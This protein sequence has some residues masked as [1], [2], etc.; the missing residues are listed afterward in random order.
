MRMHM[1]CE[2]NVNP[3]AYKPIRATHPTRDHKAA[4]VRFRPTSLIRMHT[5][6][7]LLVFTILLATK[8]THTHK[9]S[10]STRNQGLPKWYTHRSLLNPDSFSPSRLVWVYDFLFCCDVVYGLIN[11]SKYTL[12]RLELHD[13]KLGPVRLLADLIML[14]MLGPRIGCMMI[15]IIRFL[16]WMITG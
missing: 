6:L 11:R 8:N 7:G 1:L 2:P 15:D 3:T 4:Q 13:I 14:F 12:N 5:Q 16:V 10:L 9:L